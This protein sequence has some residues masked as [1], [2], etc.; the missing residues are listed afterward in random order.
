MIVRISRAKEGFADYLITGTRKDSIYTRDQKDRTITLYGNLQIFKQTEKYLNKYKNYESNYIHIT[1][2]FSK[3]DMD[4]LNEIEDEKIRDELFKEL[5]LIYIKHHTSGYDLKNEVIAYSEAHLPKIQINE[6]N[7]QRFPHIHIA[8]A[9]YNP[10]DD[11]QLRT[12]FFNNSFLDDVLQSYVCKKYGFEIPRKDETDTNEKIQDENN[13]EDKIKSKIAITRANWIELLKDIKTADELL[14]FLR[15]NLKLEENRDFKIAGSKT[16]K[17]IK[18]LNLQERNKKS[19]SLNLNGKDFS[20]FILKNDKNRTFPRHKS[21]KDLEDILLSYY[22]RRDEYISKRKSNKSKELLKNIHHLENQNIKKNINTLAYQSY[23]QKLFYEHYDYLIKDKLQGYYIKKVD[24]QI[25]INNFSKNIKIIDLEN[26]II[27]NSNS[28][29]LQEEVK[30]MIE[31]ALAKNW[32]LE[33]IEP[34]GNENFINEANRQIAALILKNK[35]EQINK[36]DLQII[37]A[38]SPTQQ[39]KVKL[40][41][42]ELNSK[43]NLQE[44]KEKLDAKLVLKYAKKNFKL[45]ISNFTITEDNKIDNLKNKQKPKNVIDFLQRELNLSTKEAIGVCVGIYEKQMMMNIKKEDMHISKAKRSK[46]E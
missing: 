9:K 20:R 46:R 14:Y 39:E 15:K 17:Y 41:N 35:E 22:E 33:N 44:L 2:S 31:I 38:K 26:Q 10:L 25:I 6:K 28:N 42:E 29:N 5:V 4:K 1:L 19:N 45:D 8:I 3:K 21:K 7:R 23:Q 12:P 13:L 16:Y 24:N 18:I 34:T 43:I 40:Q 36:N 32:K 11:T 30:I 27:S 37:R